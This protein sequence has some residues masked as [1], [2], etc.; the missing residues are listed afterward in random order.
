MA[1]PRKDENTPD[2]RE[3][4]IQSFWGL[5]VNNQ[6]NEISIGMIART[7]GYNRGTFYYYFADK[8][9]LI[10]AAVENELSDAPQAVFKLITNADNVQLS[11]ILGSHMVRLSLFMDHGGRSLIEKNVKDYLLSTWQAVLA[12]DGGELKMQARL[13]LEYMS[14]G[15]LGLFSY[16]GTL[17]QK[18]AVSFPM[19][20]LKEY[21][22]LAIRQICEAQGVNRD[23]IVARLHMLNQL[24]KIGQ[25]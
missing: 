20:F 15:V 5:L 2:A 23:E 10:K 13:I 4:L 12:P 21:S 11:D 14:S 25:K 6:L 18:D 19:S 7:A 8:E 22:A 16:L 24:N 9:A 17:P 1:R 3:M